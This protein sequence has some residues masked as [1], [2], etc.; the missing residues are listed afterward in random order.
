MY[1]RFES[2]LKLVKRKIIEAHKKTALIFSK[3]V[4]TQKPKKSFCLKWRTITNYK[5]TKTEQIRVTGSENL[6]KK[7]L[8]K[9]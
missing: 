2:I 3:N 4:T 8:E 9:F 6:K 5:N 7:T 1:K